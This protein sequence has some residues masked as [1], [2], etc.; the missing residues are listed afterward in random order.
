MDTP[1]IHA[2]LH[3]LG[4]AMVET[5]ART[6][7]D[8]DLVLWMVDGSEPLTDEDRQVAS[9][10]EGAGSSR[11]VFLVLNKIDLLTE[12]QVR[13]RAGEYGRLA[14]DA[15]QWTISALRGEN[16]DAL[17]EAVILALPLGP[18]YYPEDQVTDQ[19]ERFIAAELVREQVLLFLRQEVPHSVAV[20]VE[21][22]K[23]RRD[24][25]TYVSAVIYVERA[26]Q[27]AIVLGKEGQMLKKIGQAARQS[28]EEMLGTRV[29]LDL[30]VKV[31]PNW[32]SNEQELR[33]LGYAL[34]K[35]D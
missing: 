25:L 11:P 16:I 30:W 32:R 13:A 24:D 27:K 18:R 2:P 15:V 9:L 19:Q 8:A 26:T 31:R 22:F 34:P 1:G 6:M 4:Q 3:R 7:P 29:Y 10:L 14:P 23:E 20:V 35:D 33:R 21:E 12:D 28:I 5:A 17:V